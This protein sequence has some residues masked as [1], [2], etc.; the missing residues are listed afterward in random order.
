VSGSGWCP[1]AGAAAV[2]PG[3]VVAVEV[4][5]RELVVWRRL[6]GCPVVMDAR[7][8]H[9]WSHLA[10]DG[11]VDGD[12]VVCLAHFWR[13]AADG[14]GTKLNVKGRRDVKGPIPTF[15]ARERDGVIEAALA[16]DA[17]DPPDTPDGP[18]ATGCPL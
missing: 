13:F 18:A 11:V 3:A 1:V 17:P 16:P 5:G 15:A 9:E 2:E 14:T 10:A 4:D 6:D 7:C 12:E 8:P